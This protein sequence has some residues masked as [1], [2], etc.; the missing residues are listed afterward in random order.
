MANCSVRLTVG[1]AQGETI[2]NHGPEGLTKY[3]AWTVLAVTAGFSHSESY[4]VVIIS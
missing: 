2:T 4:D 1:A 3:I